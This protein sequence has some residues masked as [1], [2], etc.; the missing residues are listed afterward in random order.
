MRVLYFKLNTLYTL[1]STN[2]FAGETLSASGW[3]SVNPDINIPEYPPELK[4][5]KL[6]GL[7]Q[8]ECQSK[9]NGYNINK[10]FE[11]IAHDTLEYT[12]RKNTVNDMEKIKIE[13]TLDPSPNC[14]SC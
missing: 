3:G 12:L 6:L 11:I 5:T 8:E 1:D 13:Q 4:A 2:T 10:V 7:T 9:Y 14:A